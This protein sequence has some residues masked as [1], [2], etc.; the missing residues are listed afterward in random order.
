MLH[1]KLGA[2]YGTTRDVTTQKIVMFSGLCLYCLVQ[3][4]SGLHTA[5]CW[6]G[7]LRRL[8]VK[9]AD[10]LVVADTFNRFNKNSLSSF[11]DKS[12]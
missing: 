2:C 1:R 8:W 11:G 3:I 4:S 9:P 5:L 12:Y 7:S 10:E 6:V